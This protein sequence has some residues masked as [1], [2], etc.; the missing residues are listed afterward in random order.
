MDKLIG[1]HFRIIRDLSI[2][3]EA[4]QKVN[5]QLE[6]INQCVV[7]VN[8]LDSLIGLNVT[9]MCTWELVVKKAHTESK[10]ARPVCIAFTGEKGYKMRVRDIEH[11]AHAYGRTRPIA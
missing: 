5:G 4:I 1:N 9:K 8:G 10:T 7:A 11:S 6:Q 3:V 2:E